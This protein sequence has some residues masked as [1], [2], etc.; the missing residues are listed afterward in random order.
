MS[1]NCS[2]IKKAFHT[3]LKIYIKHCKKESVK[4]ISSKIT[5]DG[6]KNKLLFYKTSTKDD[7]GNLWLTVSNNETRCYIGIDEITLK[8][9]SDM[10]HT[11]IT[12]EDIEFI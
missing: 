12:E 5:D 8:Q 6:F 9:L 1:R 4:D 11:S 7:H 3:L 2:P 10:F